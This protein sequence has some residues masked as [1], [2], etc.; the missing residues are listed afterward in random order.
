MRIR[1]RLAIQSKQ[2]VFGIAR[3]ILTGNEDFLDR[4]IARRH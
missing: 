4:F 2:E 3:V 1:A